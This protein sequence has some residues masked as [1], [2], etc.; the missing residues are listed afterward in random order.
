MR[1]AALG[2]AIALLLLVPET[3]GA[4]AIAQ[5]FTELARTVGTGDRVH[6]FDLAGRE[7]VGPIAEL[8]TEVIVIG[9]GARAIRLDRERVVLVR[10]DRQDSIANGVLIGAGIGGGLG[11]LASVNC[12]GFAFDECTGPIVAGSVAWGVGIGVLADL[13]HR[14]PRDIYRAG[15]ARAAIRVQPIAGQG[16]GL[17][18][19]LTW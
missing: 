8:T 13:I 11:L 16:R 15:P 10:K 17:R 7:I 1:K 5:D 12:S 19:A 14:T 18:V 2:A 9:G 6:V 4:Q 3:A